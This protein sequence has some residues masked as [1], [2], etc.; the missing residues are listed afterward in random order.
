MPKQPTHCN[1][2]VTTVDQIWVQSDIEN[3]DNF[4]GHL[5]SHPSEFNCHKMKHSKYINKQLRELLQ[6]IH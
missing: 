3:V 1:P 5:K 2:P 4:A 6:L